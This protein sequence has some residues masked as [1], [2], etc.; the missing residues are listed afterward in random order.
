MDNILK[1]KKIIVLM[2]DGG[3]TRTKD[4]NRRKNKENGAKIALSMFG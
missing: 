2:K 4:T 1:G 3:K